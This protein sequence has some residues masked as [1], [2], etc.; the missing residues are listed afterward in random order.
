VEETLVALTNQTKRFGL[1]INEQKVKF[2]RLFRKPY[3]GGANIKFRIYEFQVISEFTYL[4]TLLTN[5]N[6]DLKPE[7]EKRLLHAYR[8]YYALTTNLKRYAVHTTEKI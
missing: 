7:I 5:N 8:A 1:E 6:N 4:G 3:N 2:M